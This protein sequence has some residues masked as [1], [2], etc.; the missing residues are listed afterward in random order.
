MNDVV[1]VIYAANDCYFKYLYISVKSLIEHVDQGKRYVIFVLSTDL[2]DTSKNKLIK[3]EKEAVKIKFKDI[4]N[5][6]DGDDLRGYSFLSIETF[7]RLY[8]PKIIHEYKKIVYLDCDTVVC[9]DVSFLLENDLR[10]Y[11]IGAIR[12]SFHDDLIAHYDVIGVDIT[13][14]FNA[15]IMVMDLE[16]FE[17][18]KIR[19][20]CLKLLLE[21]YSRKQRI[22]IYQDQDLLNIVLKGRI[23]FLDDRWNFQWQYMWRLDGLN[24]SYYDLYACAQKNPWIIHYAGDKK[25]LLYPSYP[26]ADYFWE[27]LKRTDIMVDVMMDTISALQGKIAED[28]EALN[29]ADCFKK[30][31]FPY[32]KIPANSSIAIYGAGKIGQDFREQLL[33]SVYANLVVWVDKDISKHNDIIASPTELIKRDDYQYVIIAV[34]DEDIAAEIKRYLFNIGIDGKSIIW[35][36]YRKSTSEG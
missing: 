36:D 29:K 15:G 6:I 21:D 16:K 22:Y 13:K 31:R 8:I 19:E 25:P 30:W 27:E 14:S 35:D 9:R 26:M 24:S 32:E 1:P 4:R 28:K 10:G 34:A 2:S 23:C 17:E 3:L 18:E 5:I 7:Y 12:D 33:K 20:K 11:A